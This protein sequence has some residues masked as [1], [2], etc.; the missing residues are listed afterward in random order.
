METSEAIE[1]SREALEH[2][3]TAKSKLV[4][5]QQFVLGAMF[6]DLELQILKEFKEMELEKS[7]PQGLKQKKR[8]SENKSDNPFLKRDKTLKS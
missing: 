4:L 2:I 5:G 1:I 3:R 6:R 7:K 8:P